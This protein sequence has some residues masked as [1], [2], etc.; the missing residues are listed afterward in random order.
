MLPPYVVTWQAADKSEPDHCG[1]YT[2]TYPVTLRDGSR[3]TLPIRTLPGGEQAIALLMSNQTAFAVEQALASRLI[4]L[5]RPLQPEMIVAIPTMGLDYAR[6]VAAGL[7]LPHYVAL[8]LSRKFW[9]DDALSEATVSATSPDQQKRLYLDPALL[10]RLAGKRVV[11]I[12]DVMHTGVTTAAAVRLLT[13]LGIRIAALTVV[14]T[15]S[16]T[17]RS[18][19]AG[20]DPQWPSKVLALGHIPLFRRTAGGWEPEPG[21]EAI[22][23]KQGVS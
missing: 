22:P 3:L 9:Y 6:L 20:I 17:W 21:T 13:R 15:E 5:V 8:G 16:N 19:L 12:D 18:T 14:L 23:T 10:D 7:G 1:V 4:D 2:S 11:L